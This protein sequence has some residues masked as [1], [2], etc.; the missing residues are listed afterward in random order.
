MNARGELKL[1]FPTEE[2]KEQ[3]MD[4]LKE[5]FENGEF[6]LAGDG[7]LDEIKDF[8]KWLERTIEDAKKKIG[9][10]GRVPA[11]LFLGVR[12]SDNRVIGTI[13]IR[14]ALNDFLYKYGGHIGDGVRPSE[15]KKGYATEMIRLA[16]EECKKLGINRVLMTCDKDNIASAKSI[17]NNGGV[18][19][20]EV[21]NDE[22]V[23]EQRYW[24]TLNMPKRIDKNNKIFNTSEY[25]KDKYKFNLIT[26]I[27][28]GD[29][30]LLYSDEE[31]YVFCRGEKGMPTWIWTKDNL[32]DMTIFQEIKETMD[33]YI[34]DL[35]KDRFTCKKELYYFLINSGYNKINKDD[36]FELGFLICNKTKDVKQT[37]GCM[38][39]SSE[40]DINTIAD[41]I[42][43]YNDLLSNTEQM[44]KVSPEEAMKE[45]EELIEDD[46]LYI[47]R[48]KDG[49]IVC[50]ANYKKE[51]ET[52]RIGHVYT[53][54]EER[55]KG[56]AANLIHDM[57]EQLLDDRL[58][59]LLYTDYNYPASNKAYMNAGYEDTG[60]LINFS[61]SGKSK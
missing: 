8:D 38:V 14:H 49:K 6:V 4:Y 24:I 43:K 26:K 56:Y 2:Y 41:Y 32:K 22:G 30:T 55:G 12:K 13:Q 50:M 27:L 23:I 16:L 45:A 34:T 46:K 33:L 29:N 17:M 57:T 11:T 37:D 25:Q 31:N 28:K 61:C 7:G 42:F 1:V 51:E 36:Y 18:L 3:V 60:I 20:N 54:E 10:G 39:K 15:R 9:E 21:V 5:H 44:E 53:P 19:E 40:Q 58:V 47:W 48:N 59:P 35:E 52:A